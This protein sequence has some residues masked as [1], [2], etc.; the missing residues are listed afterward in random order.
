MDRADPEV[1]AQLVAM[2]DT[3][4]RSR[5]II[6]HDLR[7][8]NLGDLHWVE[9]HLLFPKDTSIQDAHR[10]ATEIEGVI[11]AGLEPGAYV[12]TH[13]EAI[14]DHASVHEHVRH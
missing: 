9:V 5:N 1:H 8:R 2:L 14:E 13:L 7:H 6:Y 3:E 10:M 4:T 12:S 11:E